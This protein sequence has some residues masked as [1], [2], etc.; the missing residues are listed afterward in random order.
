M[1]LTCRCWKWPLRCPFL[2]R[3]LK[4]GASCRPYPSYF[5]K[6]ILLFFRVIPKLD[7]KFSSAFRWRA[8][9]GPD[10]VRRTDDMMWSGKRGTSFS[11]SVHL[12]HSVVRKSIGSVDCESSRFLFPLLLTFLRTTSCCGAAMSFLVEK[13]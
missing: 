4:S 9:E 3:Q 10:S 6:Y 2:R 8:K 5:P 7:L 1:V 12:G 13:Q 11:V